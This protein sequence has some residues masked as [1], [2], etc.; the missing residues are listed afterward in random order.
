MY[1][2]GHTSARRL[3]SYILTDSVR[4]V[5]IF[6]FSSFLLM[7]FFRL[8]EIFMLLLIVFQLFSRLSM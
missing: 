6:C 1:S 5:T 2:S 7:C 3:Y 8:N 4:I